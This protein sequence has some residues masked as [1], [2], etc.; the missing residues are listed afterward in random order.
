MPVSME[1]LAM[2]PGR[3][4]VPGFSG[5]RLSQ[6]RR[7]RGLTQEELANATG[8][9]RQYVL[10]LEQGSRRPGMQTFQA[11]AGA[12]GVRPGE[13]LDA[14]RLSLLQLRLVAGLTQEETAEAAGVGRRTYSDIERG[15]TQGVDVETVRALATAFGVS[16]RQVNTGLRLTA[17]EPTNP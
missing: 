7:S 2:S 12:L 15:H 4:A 5:S 3:L 8:L 6:L 10:A 9:A 16:E 13:L 14:T 1:T 11:L 17:Q